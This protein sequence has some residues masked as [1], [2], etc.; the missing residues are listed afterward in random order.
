MTEGGKRVGEKE[1]TR[2]ERQM[3]GAVSQWCPQV[4]ND[5]TWFSGLTPAH[6]MAEFLLPLGGRREN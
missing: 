4:R 5:V 6:A 3:A 2:R 1:E